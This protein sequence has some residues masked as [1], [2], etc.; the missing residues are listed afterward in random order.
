MKELEKYTKL[1]QKDRVNKTNEF[2]NLISEK[3]IKYSNRLSSKEK[4]EL[5][6]IK[7]KS[8]EN[9]FNAYYMKETKLCGGNDKEVHINDKVF[10]I[11]KKKDM[12]N[13]VC[14]YEKNNYNDAEFFFNYLAK[15][16][17]V[18]GLK[19]EEPEWV[20]LG[21]HSSIID[22][23]ATAN[24]Y[25]GK[26]KSDYN[27][28]VFLLGRNDKIYTQ[29]K[30][31]SLCNN[32]YVSQV[33]KVKTLYKK[34]MSVFSKI[35]LQI[36]TK[37]GG[38]SYKAIEDRRIK[39]RKLMIIGVD[40]SHIKDKRTG[41]GM[42][43][44]INDSFTN[45]FNKEELIKEKNNREQLQY[46][47]RSFIETAFEVYKKEN[48]EYPK[49]IIIYRQGVSFQQKEYLKTE[50]PQI[51]SFCEAKKILYYY[52]LVN[53]KTNYKFIE[54]ANNKF[55]NP[56]RGLLVVDGVTNKNFFEFYIQPQEVTLG[57]ATPTC[58]HVAY[59]NLDIPELILKLTYDLCYIYSNWNGSISVPNVLKAAG[60]LAK[61][62][63]K[64]TYSELNKNLEKGQAYI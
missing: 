44:T 51:H 12:T 54:K 57:S 60:K 6:G 3:E 39:D 37:L 64:Y 22:W 29:L 62:V 53:I 38:I 20:E 59:G 63:A 30:R 17:K 11:L 31:H 4:C 34:T 16:S 24:D 25:F 56:D 50:I 18:F 5:Y 49:G 33:V 7:V 28:A 10:P 19:I 2:L 41:V 45:F 9:L 40:S 21:N 23:T 1:F 52:I 14:F 15:A 46:C 61:M 35:I 43:A 32:G 55:I 26:N 36:N 58:F 8:L 47:I 42:V 27:F 48:K 13:W